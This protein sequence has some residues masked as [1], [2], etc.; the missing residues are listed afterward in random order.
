MIS[1][2]YTI[3]SFRFRP[4]SYC[5]TINTKSMRIISQ[6]HTSISNCICSFSNSYT[7]VSKSISTIS[8]SSSIET[9]SLYTSTFRPKSST[10]YCSIYIKSF[11]RR[12]DTTDT[13]STISKYSQICLLPSCS[14]SQSQY[15]RL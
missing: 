1:N 15:I 5:N 9:N 7:I 11:S 3:T 6:C 14:K 13:N 4:I 8:H 10:L 12:K 2:S